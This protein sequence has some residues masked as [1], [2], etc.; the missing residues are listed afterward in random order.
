MRVEAVTGCGTGHDRGVGSAFVK[1]RGEVG[2]EETVVGRLAPDAVE[3]DQ[4]RPR[5]DP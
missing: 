1:Q 4:P 3:G 2:G 5:F